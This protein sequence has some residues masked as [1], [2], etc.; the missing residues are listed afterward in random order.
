[1]LTVA[2]TGGIGS[3]KSTV[4]A[5]LADLGA[6]VVDSD[7]LAREVVAPGT[8]GLA[9][10]TE[11]FGP[12]VL[13]TDGSLDRAALA[14]IVFRD[15]EARHRL[16]AIT[17]PLVRAAFRQARD[18]AGPGAIVVNDIPLVRTVADAAQFHLV[19]TV[20]ADEEVRVAR[21]IDRGLSEDD[22]RA[23]MRAQ[24][25]DD[26]RRPLTDV[27]LHNGGDEADLRRIVRTVWTERLVPFQDNLL[28][29]RPAARA[30]SSGAVP[31]GPSPLP[32]LCA[33]VSAATGGLPCAPD[34]AG[35]LPRVWDAT[36]GLPGE[37][38]V[39]GAGPSLRVEVPDL[40][41][42]DALAPALARAGFPR[43]PEDGPAAAS[44]DRRVRA[45]DSGGTGGGDGAGNGARAPHPGRAERIHAGA[46]PGSPVTVH[47]AIVSPP[48][49]ESAGF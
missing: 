9:T 41:T 48:P 47:L 43:V 22:A 26:E 21:L 15:A 14:A 38:D 24:L 4:S 20:A 33:R 40:G 34:A 16:E 37:W 35:G 25:S 6:V 31:G 17:H 23:R 29:G 30:G 32:L 19:L 3:G 45:G 10:V 42:A 8:P 18:A 5:A 28:A 49:G 39:T 46:D 11:A 36:G 2:V 7:R 13:A 27:W 1:M 44:G 12:T